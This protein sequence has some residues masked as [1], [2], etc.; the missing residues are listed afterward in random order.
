MPLLS[1]STGDSALDD[2]DVGRT[3]NVTDLGVDGTDVT[4]M[5]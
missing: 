2:V 3:G 1:I 5:G 4:T